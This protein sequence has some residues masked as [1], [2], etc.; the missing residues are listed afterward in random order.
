MMISLKA[1]IA[2]VGA[3]LVGLAAAV[4]LNNAGYEVIIIDA[5]DPTQEKI[6]AEKEP[7]DNRI[8]AISPQNAAW[9]KELEVWQLLDTK[10]IGKMREMEIW[11]D[12]VL[13]P[14]TLSAEDANVDVMGFII[15]GH[16]LLKALL[17]RIEELSIPTFF[18]KTCLN[19]N[20]F[21]EKSATIVSLSS[22][23]SIECKLLLAADGANSWVRQQLE[24]PI[25]KKSY[26]QV[27][28]VANFKVS[29]PHSDIAR[30]WFA[31]DIENKNSILALLPLPENQISIVWSVSNEFGEH[32]LNLPEDVFTQEV[33]KAGAYCLG[34]LQLITAPASFS[35]SL[36]KSAK[37]I[38]DGVIFIGDASHQ[39]HPMAGQGMNIGFRDVIDLVKTLE[40]KQAFQS[41]N[42]P[43][44]LRSYERER[45]ADIA[46][47]VFVTDGLYKLFE[48]Q[49][50]IFKK[51]R[52]QGLSLTNN[53]AIKKL[54]VT[55][56]ISL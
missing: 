29:K 42:D 25:Q 8:Y 38:H 51:I 9:L 48:S 21:K 53:A 24:V 36:Q 45:K 18:Q 54:L 31:K 41:I 46:Q 34:N 28:I 4:A 56:A 30:Q 22:R 11:G 12:D 6:D 52:N 17:Q 16:A 3:G 40:N 15:E 55:H 20:K 7:W 35:L 49:G 33:A 19:I 14:L 10:R 44:L 1:D 5:R 26:D 50:N 43:H 32:L 23:E 39:V 27:G 47:M 37:L 13:A 2:I